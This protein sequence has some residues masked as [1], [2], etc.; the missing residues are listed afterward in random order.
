MAKASQLMEQA[1][2]SREMAE[3]AKRLAGSL[4]D[5]PDRTRLL[6]YAEELDEQTAALEKQAAHA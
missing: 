1:T 2:A 3:R 5:G 6:R 4:I